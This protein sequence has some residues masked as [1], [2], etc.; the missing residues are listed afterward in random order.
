MSVFEEREGQGWKPGQRG[1]W[2]PIWKD[3]GQK[4]VD[5][6]GSGQEI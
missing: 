3:G 5:L 2:K 4:F 1:F 6:I